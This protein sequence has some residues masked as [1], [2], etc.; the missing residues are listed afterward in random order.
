MESRIN[1]KVDTHL[2]AFK[3]DIK[4][5]FDVNNSDI[6]GDAN[7]NTF[8]QFIFD[9]DAL[10]LSKDDFTRRKRVKNS[11]PLQIRCCACRA[12]GEQCTRRRKDGLDYCGTHIKG[13]PYGVV[14]LNKS[15]VNLLSKK[16][17]W[18]QEIKGIQYFIDDSNNIYLH[19]DILNNIKNPTIIGKYSKDHNGTYNICGEF[20]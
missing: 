20:T 15:E 8:L 3:E 4:E 2:S 13:T 6:S 17:V 19:E 12:N 18:V 16:Q 11:V 7:K 10:S 9:Y 1:K 5:W 14:Q